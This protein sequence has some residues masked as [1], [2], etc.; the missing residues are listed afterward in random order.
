ME[1]VIIRIDN[2]IR[3]VGNIPDPVAHEIQAAFTRQNPDYAKAKAFGF[4]KRIP[5]YLISWTQNHTADRSAVELSVPRGGYD[6]VLGL[7]A[8]SNIEPSAIEDNR[9]RGFRLKIPNSSVTPYDYQLRLIHAAETQFS[10]TVGGV[11]LW[12]SVQASGKTTAALILASRLKCKTLVIIS[13]SVLMRQWCRR[14]EVELGFRP[15][16][17]G[18]G[19]YNIDPPI[20]IAMQQSLKTM[21]QEDVNRFVLLIGD[22]IQQFAA[23]TFQQSV[24]RFP[25]AYRLGVSGDERRADHKEFLIYD[26]FGPVTAEVKS[27]ELV[28]AG[29]IHEVEVRVVPT[30]FTC[31]WW[32]DIGSRPG[33]SGDTEE[34]TRMGRIQAKIRYLEQLTDELSKNPDRNALVVELAREAVEQAGQAIVLTTRRDHCHVLDQQLTAHGFRS[35]LLI[36]GPDYREMFERTLRMFTAQESN[37]AVGTYQA[38]GVGFDLP[39]VARGICAAPVANSKGGDK[40]WRQYRGRFARTAYGKVD[41]A[42]YYLFDINV[43]GLKPLRHLVRWNA[44]V[45]VRDGAEWIPAKLWIE[46]WQND[47]TTKRQPGLDSTGDDQ[48]REDDTTGDEQCETRSGRKSRGR[49]GDRGNQNEESISCRP[50]TGSVDGRDRGSRRKR[51]EVQTEDRGLGVSTADQIRPV[52]IRRKR[53][54]VG[55]D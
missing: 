43:F 33:L 40:Q 3:I 39:I 47:A 16:I 51:S 35:G 23:V 17:V 52:G 37:V 21:H 14:V 27:A 36:G 5:K 8:K 12:R 29:R 44:R 28:T 53:S 22:E 46:R 20:V 4:K 24:D 50:G 38:I 2:R 25:A 32:T 41:A 10:N 54:E 1:S 26:Q 45:V 30:N 34:Q 19:K 55:I 6:Q 15:G 48:D 42:I 11:A 9:H 49:I 18:A 13:N 31:D 7:L